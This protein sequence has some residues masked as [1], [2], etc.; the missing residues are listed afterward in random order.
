MNPGG[1]KKRNEK[2]KK[3]GRDFVQGSEG[4]GT[5]EDTKVVG[6]TRERREKAVICFQMFFQ[7]VGGHTRWQEIIGH[8]TFHIIN[9]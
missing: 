7:P 2:K 1:L 4:Q 9:P 8:C 5:Q 3:K 6:P